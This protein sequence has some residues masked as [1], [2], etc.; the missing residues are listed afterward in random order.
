V[1]DGRPACFSD[2]QAA[3]ALALLDADTPVWLAA[4]CAAARPWL[5]FHT[6]APEA[7]RPDL[8]RF[9]FAGAF[10]LPAPSAFDLGTDAYPDRSTTL[11]IETPGIAVP[12]ELTLT[13]PGIDGTAHARLPLPRAFRIARGELAELF[14]RGL[15]LLLTDGTRALALPRTTRVEEG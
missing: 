9:A 3:I 7:A 10:D 14:P 4:E 12:G 5:A 6:G 2:A 13:G 11:V 1:P 15:D 8:A